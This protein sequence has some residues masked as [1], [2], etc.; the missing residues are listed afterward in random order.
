MSL[1]VIFSKSLIG[2]VLFSYLVLYLEN[3]RINTHYK[4]INVESINYHR[5]NCSLSLS[6]PVSFS[7]SKVRFHCKVLYLV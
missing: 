2:D 5:C 6:L 3:E 4:K 7:V 1:T